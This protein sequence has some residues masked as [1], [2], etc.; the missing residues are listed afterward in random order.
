MSSY[1][2]SFAANPNRSRQSLFQSS[3]LVSLDHSISHA[4]LREDVFRLGGVF[5]DLPADVRHVHAEDL[6]VICL[7]RPPDFANQVIIGQHAP[8]EAPQ[9]RDQLEFVLRQPRV[10][11]VDIHAV[12]VIVDDQPARGKAV[13]LR[14]AR[15]AARRARMADRRAQ[16]I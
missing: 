12:F 9:Q 13:F 10:A 4:D 5:F 2:K 11:P 8:G 14:D 6:V 7:V 3:F 15:V 1:I 16:R